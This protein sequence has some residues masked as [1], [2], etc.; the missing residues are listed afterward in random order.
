MKVF[1]PLFILIGIVA[2]FMGQLGTC[3]LAFGIAPIMHWLDKQSLKN[4]NRQ[5]TED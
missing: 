2:L 1:A 3:L 5:K 4:I